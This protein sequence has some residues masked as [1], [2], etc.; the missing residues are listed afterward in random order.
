MEKV[1][2][3]KKASGE[4]T[5]A[6]CSQGVWRGGAPDG[7]RAKGHSQASQGVCVVAHPGQP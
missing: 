3:G 6:A 1:T 5:R 7:V 4:V 2:Q